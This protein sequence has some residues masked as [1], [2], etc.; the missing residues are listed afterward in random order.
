PMHVADDVLR[1]VLNALGLPA[2]TSAEVSQSRDHLR[3]EAKDA[4]VPKLVTGVA[5]RPIALDTMAPQAT[6]LDG[7]AY[8]IEF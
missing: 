8:R 3:A 6:L 7:Q 2:D 1:T 4:A 5:G